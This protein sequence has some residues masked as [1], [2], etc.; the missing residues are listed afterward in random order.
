MRNL[1]YSIAIICLIMSCQKDNL[2][3]EQGITIENNQESQTSI[4]LE[5]RGNDHSIQ[6]KVWE[7]L[8]GDG[9]QFKK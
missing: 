9:I 6:G 2:P 8:D 1:T 7:D 3:A 4:E 5:T